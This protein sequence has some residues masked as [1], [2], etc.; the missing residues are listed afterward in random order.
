[1]DR[2]RAPALAGPE[3]TLVSAGLTRA[4][5][6]GRTPGDVGRAADAEA[7]RAIG[8]D[9]DAI[10]EAVD[11]EHGEGAWKAAGVE[12]RRGSG[13]LLGRLLPESHPF[14]SG[15]KKTLELGLREAMA[16]RSRTITTTHL[17][18]GLLRDPGATASA[19]IETEGA[20]AKLR[21]GSRLRIRPLPEPPHA[22][23]AWEAASA[24]SRECGSRPLAS[25][26][27]LERLA[28]DLNH[29]RIGTASPT[30]QT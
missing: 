26:E 10:R 3:P 28:H 25:I 22:R 14:T 7:L 29:C 11:R 13:G 15:V 27:E 23:D 12:R 5:P 24:T 2:P 30:M 1:M 16:D 4:H 17:L 9:L 18:R 20:V 6:D 19:L 21:A 8:I